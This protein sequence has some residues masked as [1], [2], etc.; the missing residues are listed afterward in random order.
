MIQDN[1]KKLKDLCKEFNTLKYTADQIAFV[2]DHR[3]FFKL[4][5]DNDRTYVYPIYKNEEVTYDHV[6]YDNWA[7]LDC[8]EEHI[9]ERYCI[10]MKLSYDLV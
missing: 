5:L 8:I 1:L 6:A 3:K 4:R 9:T 7:E 10:R 2:E